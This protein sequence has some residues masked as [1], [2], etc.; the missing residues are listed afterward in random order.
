MQRALSSL[1]IVGVL[2]ASTSH[3]QPQSPRIDKLKE[4]NWPQIDALDRE[5]T[6]FILAGRHG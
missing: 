1:V 4:F 6:M 5:R 3:A 2:G